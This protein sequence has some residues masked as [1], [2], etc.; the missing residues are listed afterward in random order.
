MLSAAITLL[1]TAVTLLAIG[2]LVHSAIAAQAAWER[3]MREGEVLRAGIA[4]HSAAS[5]ELR[6]RSTASRPAPRRALAMRR[7]ASVPQRALRACAAV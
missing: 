2:V 1:L 6:M 4:L 3:L 7:P 5:G